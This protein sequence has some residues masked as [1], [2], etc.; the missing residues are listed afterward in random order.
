MGLIGLGKMGQ[1]HCRVISNQRE[2]V[3]VGL[4]D[5]NPKVAQDFSA[6]YEVPA[7]KSLG[8]L[9]RAVDAVSIATP[10]PTHFE[11]ATKCLENGVHVLLEKPITETLD[12][13]LELMELAERSGCIVQIGHIERFNPTFVE[14]KKV[15][16]DQ[17][18]IAVDFRRLSAYR[19]SNT[20]VDV[21]LDLMVHDLDLAINLIG[22]E[23]AS[24][25]ANGLMPFSADLDHVVAQLCFPGGPLVTL[26]ASRVTEEK[27]RSIEVTAQEAYIAADMLNK[28]I[29]VHRRSSSVYTSNNSNGVKYH[30]E[31]F[32]ER[33]LV[34]NHEPLVAEIRHFLQCVNDHCRPCVSVQDGYKALRLALQIHEHVHNQMM[35]P[36]D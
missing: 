17:K 20:D 35:Q 18:I 4:Y 11:I 36:A 28:S 13:A 29:A 16:E 25:S 26:T 1:H 15:L 2:A 12:Q 19:V 34:P 27:I 14:L 33:I 6:R 9:T 21:V 31:S 7:F 10:T 5:A 32:I 22:R 23:P 3:L 30:Q 8:E 24:I